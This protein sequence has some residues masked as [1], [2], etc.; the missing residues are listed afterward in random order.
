MHIITLTKHM[1]ESSSAGVPANVGAG[2]PVATSFELELPLVSAEMRAAGAAVIESLSRV[3]SSEGLAE[4]VYIA[5]ATAP[6]AV[7]RDQR[8]LRRR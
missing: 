1:T 3:V 5:M 8:S 2:A 4:R 6:S 7:E